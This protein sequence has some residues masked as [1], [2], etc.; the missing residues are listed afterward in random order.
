MATK[1]R[2]F[3]ILGFLLA[4]SAGLSPSPAAAQSTPPVWDASR[5]IVIDEFRLRPDGGPRPEF[6]E[7]RNV[8]A[9]AIDISGWLIQT[10]PNGPHTTLYTLATIPLNTVVGP[11]CSFLLASDDYARAEAPDQRYIANLTGWGIGLRNRDNAIVDAV[12]YVSVG[13]LLSQ[14]AE[15]TLA[16]LPDTWKNLDAE[17]NWSFFRTGDDTN[18]NGTDFRLRYQGDPNNSAAPCARTIPS[19]PPFVMSAWDTNVTLASMPLQAGAYMENWLLRKVQGGSGPD[20]APL[21]VQLDFRA[22]GGGFM[23]FVDAPLRCFDDTQDRNYYSCFTIP[24]NAKP[25]ESTVSIVVQDM[26][27]RTSVH[28]LSVTVTPAPDTDGDGLPDAWETRYGFDPASTAG[29]NGPDGDPDGDGRTNLQEFQDGSHPRGTFTRYFAEGAVNQFFQTRLSIFNP[30]AAKANTVMRLLGSNGSRTSR[31]WTYEPHN[32]EVLDLNSFTI[33]LPDTTFSIVLESDQ[34]IVSDRLM[35]WQSQ[36]WQATGGFTNVYGSHL[37]TAIAAPS[38]TWYLAEGATGGPYRLYYLLQNPGA[39][40]AEVTVAYLR[41]SPLAPIQK[42]YTVAAASRRTLDVGGEDPGLAAGEVSAS[43]T[44]TQPIIVERSMYFSTPSQLMAAGH[45]GAG[46]TA[47]AERW[48]LAEGATGFFDEFVLIANPGATRSDVTVTYLLQDGTTFSENLQVAAQSRY[49]IPV[50]SRDPRL[51]ATQVSVIV[52]STNHV[53]VVVERVMWWPHGQWYEA[54]LSA[55]ATGTGTSWAIPGLTQGNSLSEA[56]YVLIA[57]TGDTAGTATV[58]GYNGVGTALPPVTVPLPAHSR[59][60]LDF[61]TLPQ[62]WRAAGSPSVIVT[63]D[64][65]PIVVERSQ[66]M[67]ANGQFWSAGGTALATR[68]VP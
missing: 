31:F 6:I 3:S 15:T 41:P 55:G 38:T 26:L 64:G 21:T 10:D 48:F 61:S 2:R 59:T 46:V 62:A 27:G 66:Y 44:S 51:A 56:N 34:P 36:G 4:A 19:S 40:D 42:T 49:T 68:L 53:P 28:P 47:P 37:E 13:G 22:A 29:E 43:L 39:S 57:N 23:S 17:R 54:S 32:T 65:V 9:G 20:T 67:S 30:G 14:F 5:G 50:N 11:G 18:D 45:D 12:G 63:S 7:L 24:L 16:P 60:S 52:E 8:S 25:G 35:F 58:T 33:N 1:R